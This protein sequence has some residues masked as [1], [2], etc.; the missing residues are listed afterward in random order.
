MYRAG[1]LMTFLRELCR[2]RL[3]LVVVQEARWES[4][5]TSPAGEYVSFHGKGNENHEPSTSF[6][7]H[8]RNISAVKRVEFVSDRKS[9][10]ILVVAGFVS[11]F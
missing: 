7:A 4:S 10:I 3:D 5:G 2:Y 6:F 1:S 8:K 11:L 9:F